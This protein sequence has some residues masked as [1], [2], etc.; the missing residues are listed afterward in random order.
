M[1]DKKFYTLSEIEDIHIG[2][3]G[4][5]ERDNYEERMQ[6]FLVG[7]AI[8]QTRQSKILTQEELGAR[9]GDVYLGGFERAMLAEGS[10][11]SASRIEEAIVGVRSV[12]RGA[13]IRRALVMG[14]DSLDAIRDGLI[15]LYPDMSL[16]QYADAMAEA[17]R[18]AELAGRADVLDEAAHGG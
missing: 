1:E 9:I 10:R 4:T 2:K 16:A 8:K 3:K 15:S 5:P 7:E 18:A 14:A 17:L 6:S 11:I 12:V 13:T